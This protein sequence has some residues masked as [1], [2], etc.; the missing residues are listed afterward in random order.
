MKKLG[1]ILAIM[2]LSGIFSSHPARA[3]A[4][5]NVLQTVKPEHPPI[6]LL[7]SPNKDRIYVLDDQG[8]ISI[9]ALDGQLRDKIQVGTDVQQIEAGPGDNVLFLLS[10]T[11]G[12]IRIISIDLIENIDIDDSPIKGRPD[13]PVTIVVFSDFQ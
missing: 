5:W 8:W 3:A 12:T 10:R 11:A 7:I 4:E 13:A 2:L 6:D 9:Y 1:L